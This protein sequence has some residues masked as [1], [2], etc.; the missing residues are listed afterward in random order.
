MLRYS[1][2][3]PVD[4]FN[5]YFLII[6]HKSTYLTNRHSDIS[7]SSNCQKGS[8]RNHIL[9]METVLAKS[10]SSSY[11]QPH[12]ISHI[13]SATFPQ[14]HSLTHIPPNQNLLHSLR[15]K[16]KKKKNSVRT[17]RPTPGTL[18]LIGDSRASISHVVPWV[19]HTGGRS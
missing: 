1:L 4:T 3:A 6:R 9:I 8:A 15:R 10:E 19:D 7:I 5:M 2:S 16:K 18:A 11:P 17:D 12:S 13:P 14:P